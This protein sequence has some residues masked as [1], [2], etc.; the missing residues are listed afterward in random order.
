[1]CNGNLKFK[2]PDGAL[3]STNKLLILEELIA[4]EEC[5]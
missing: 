2:L 1:M 5:E 3:P 4:T